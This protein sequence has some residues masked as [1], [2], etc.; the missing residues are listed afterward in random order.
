MIDKGS[1]GL[2]YLLMYCQNPDNN[3]LKVVKSCLKEIRFWT[4]LEL[5]LS[6]NDAIY[7]SI[8]EYLLEDIFNEK[9]IMRSDHVYNKDLPEY[10]EYGSGYKGVADGNYS[11][12]FRL[13][14]NALAHGQFKLDGNLVRAQ[15]MGY[16]A[17]FDIK[18]FESLV[19][20]TLS[21]SDNTL[22][23]DMS[24]VSALYNTN[25]ELPVKH[26]DFLKYISDGNLI[27]IKLTLKRTGQENIKN[28]LDL[29]NIDA[30]R[31]NFVLIS[32]LFLHVLQMVSNEREYKQNYFYTDLKEDINK[33]LKGFKDILKAD[34]IYPNVHNSLFNNPQ[35]QDLPSE[36]KIQMIIS[37]K[38][39]SIDQAKVHGTSIHLLQYYFNLLEQNEEMP[40]NNYI[41]NQTS[42]LLVLAY[43]ASLIIGH[44]IW[45]NFYYKK[46]L[47]DKYQGR[48]T[49]RYVKA[50]NVYKYMIKNVQRAC[51]ELITYDAPYY[52]QEKWTLQLEK[53][54]DDYDTYRCKDAGFYFF[55]FMRN[56]L[57]HNTITIEGDMIHFYNIHPDLTIPTYSKKKKVWQEKT[58]SKPEP[59]YEICLKKND[60]IDFVTDV[61]REIGIDNK[62]N[63]SSW[64]K[65]LNR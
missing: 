55:R 10:Y 44:N 59:I 37:E 64:T 6:N 52:L 36:F 60:L 21:S 57:V 61:Y 51:T 41:L 5:L 48:I 45:D 47:L 18:W 17:V 34:I 1:L 30:S 8:P 11:N 31:I 40:E 63:I 13:L 33:V 65:K 25:E 2:K 50:E 29:K 16:I 27:F 38:C 39:S 28:L 49:Y 32:S 53:F 54:I 15:N 20:L 26:E 62:V 4:S 3:Y 35:F 42:N 22:R 14:R 46:D 24:N 12:Q 7:D 19:T 43:T 58:I 9:K 56:A 23:K